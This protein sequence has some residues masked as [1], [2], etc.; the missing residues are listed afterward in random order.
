MDFAA[1]NRGSSGNVSR[2][3]YVAT[4]VLRREITFLYGILN[5]RCSPELLEANGV[6]WFEQIDTA[7]FA[8]RKQPP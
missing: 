5:L 2:A 1:G 4:R 8:Q 7:L 6:W 3:A